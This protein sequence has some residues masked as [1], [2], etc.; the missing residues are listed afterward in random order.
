MILGTFYR[1]INILSV[2]FFYY[3]H[4]NDTS[5][6]LGIECKAKKK[7]N[8]KGARKKEDGFMYLEKIKMYSLQRGFC[9]KYLR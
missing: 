9:T 5:K 1:I 3:T 8:L 4:L 6:N 2:A 7:Q